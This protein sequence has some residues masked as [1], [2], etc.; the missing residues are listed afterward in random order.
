MCCS[1]AGALGAS[2][3]DVVESTPICTQITDLGGAKDPAGHGEVVG[4]AKEAVR[5]YVG[6]RGSGAAHRPLKHTHVP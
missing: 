3:E 2:T 1:V 4:L 6:V 5:M